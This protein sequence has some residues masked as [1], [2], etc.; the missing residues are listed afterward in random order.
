MRRLVVDR[1]VWERGEVRVGDVF[2]GGRVRGV[3]A[4][5]RGDER[6]DARDGRERGVATDVVWGGRS[7][8]GVG[9]GSV[10]GSG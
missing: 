1:G 5:E 7:G 4:A 2:D 6:V 10:G 3:R 8:G 9:G